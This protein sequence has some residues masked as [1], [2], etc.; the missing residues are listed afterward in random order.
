MMYSSKWRKSKVPIARTLFLLAVLL[1]G[2]RATE[3][4]KTASAPP[5]VGTVENLSFDSYL[6]AD[7]PAADGF[8][9]PI[10]NED[11]RGSYVEASTGKM[12]LGWYVATAFNERY[13]LGLHPGEDWNGKGGG[14]TDLGQ[15]VYAVAKGR[16]KFAGPCGQPWGNVIILDHVFFENHQ[17]VRI[18]SLYAHLN[19]I[20]VRAGDLIERRQKIGAI[21]QDPEKTFTAH[22]HLELRQDTSLAPTYWPSSHQKDERWI[23]EHYAEPSKFIDRHRKLFVPRREPFLILV[24][25]HRFKM[26]MYRKGEMLGEYDISLGQESGAKE[27]QGDN[28][29]PKGMYFVLH[30]H[31]GKFDGLYGR[32]FGGHWIKINYPNSY[33]AA[34]GRAAGW[35]TAEQEAR[36]ASAWARREPTLESTRLGGGIGFHGWASEWPNNGPRQLSWGCV[37]MHLYDIRKIFDEVPQGAMVVIF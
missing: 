5:P 12:H 25:Q 6:D 20:A 22:L 8:D 14:N 10:G 4:R 30:K 29:T 1:S 36:I 26:R 17:R 37:V 28:R 24:D 21:G 31:R 13:A 9:Y 3:G 32:Y 23:R 33:D 35:I 7:L 15:P 16:V 11:G 2:C 19:S 34:R 27:E 18:Q